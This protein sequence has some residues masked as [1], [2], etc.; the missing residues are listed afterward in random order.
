M[1][2]APKASFSG[3][4]T[5]PG[6]KSITH[7]AIMLN[8]IALGTATLR[9]ACLG[10]DCMATAECMR[11]LGA[12]VTFDGTTATVTG[13]KKLK[14]GQKLNVANSATT[15]R[16]LAG[17]LCGRRRVCAHA[18]HDTHHRAAV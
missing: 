8:A 17:L 3:V 9:N 18:T 16:L 4:F 7:R 10:A 1:L 5:P 6:D 13:A 12:T 11:A 2:I 15:M 14:S